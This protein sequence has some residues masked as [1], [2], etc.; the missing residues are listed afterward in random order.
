MTQSKLADLEQRY[1]MIESQFEGTQYAIDRH[2]K[3]MFIIHPQGV[4]PICA[5]QVTDFFAE[6]F[7]VWSTWGRRVC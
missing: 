7:E 4:L 5:D 2:G 1:M 6:A 3:G